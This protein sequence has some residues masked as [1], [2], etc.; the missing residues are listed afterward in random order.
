MSASDPITTYAIG[1]KVTY[2]G[3]TMIAS[4]PITITS[5]D[6]RELVE[7]HLGKW[8]PD[9]LWRRA[10]AYARRKLDLYRERYPEMKSYNND[11]LVLLTADTV[12]ELNLSDQ[13]NTISRERMRAK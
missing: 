10:E 4:D 9:D 2:N 12:G 13:L 8:V 7:D 6:L 3:D 1:D 11:Y 5:G